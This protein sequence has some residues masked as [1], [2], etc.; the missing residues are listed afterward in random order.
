MKELL[1]RIHFQK[2]GVAAGIVAAAI[3]VIG[4]VCVILK[5]EKQ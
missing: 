4:I 5:R 3:A 2:K 1:Q